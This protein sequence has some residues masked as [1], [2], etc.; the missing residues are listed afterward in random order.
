MDAVEAGH[1]H[2]REGEVGIGARV[3]EANFD[4]LGLRIGRPRNAARGRAVAHRIG[5]QH[6]G[7]EARHQALVA[8]G[9]RIGEAVQ[10]PGV[11][12]DAADVVEAFL[13]EVGVFVAGHHRLAV[14]PDRLVDVHARAVVAI[15]GL[16]HEGRGLA[17]ALRDHVDAVF[18]DLHVVGHRHQRAELEAEFVLRGG[19]LMVVLLDESRPS[20]PSPPAS[21]RACPAPNPAAEPG[22]SPPWCACGGRGFRPRMACRNW[23]GTRSNRQ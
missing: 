19:D 8:V 20:A 23:R 3:G 4:T 9:R 22:S 5:E 6:R 1:Q 13:A 14:L 16:G 18:V 7:L 10:R 11:L 2:R 21:R 15:N 12:D 17:V